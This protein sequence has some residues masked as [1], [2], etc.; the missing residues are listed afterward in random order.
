GMAYTV[1]GFKNLYELNR[2]YVFDQSQG[3]SI[4]LGAAEHAWLRQISRL[5]IW[6]GTAILAAIWAVPIFLKA[7]ERVALLSS[8]V[9]FI[10]AWLLPGFLFQALI[11]IEDPG[12]TLFSVPAICIVGAYLIFVGTQ[13]IVKMREA[14]LI[15]A[16]VVNLT[17]LLNFFSLPATAENT[18]GLQSLQNAF[19]FRVFETSI[20]ELR[21]QDNI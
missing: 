18:G 2:N 1:G 11:H 6:N 17:L 12:H 19:L 20:G 15:F 3:Q 14:F 21:Y 13:Q 10:V 16:V 5:V 4:V 8:Q 7:K 9:V